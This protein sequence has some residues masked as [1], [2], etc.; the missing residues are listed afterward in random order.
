MAV[1]KPI[2]ADSSQFTA[3]QVHSQPFKYIAGL[4]SCFEK[5]QI[6]R[7]VSLFFNLGTT[8][9]PILPDLAGGY[10]FARLGFSND[11]PEQ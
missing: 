6:G 4:E 1:F 3:F 7:S 8:E 5:K 2:Q 11:T 10:F 9:T